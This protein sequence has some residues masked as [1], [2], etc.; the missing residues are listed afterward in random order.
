MRKKLFLIIL[1]AILYWIIKNYVPY[2]GYILYPITLLVTFFHETGHAFFALITG[3]MVEGI[4]I[5]SDGSGFARIGGGWSFLVLPGGYIGSALWGNLLLYMALYKE[6]Y[7]RFLLYFIIAILVFSAIV[8][9]NSIGTSALLIAFAAFLV[10]MS[11]QKKG[12]ISNVLLILG[13]TSLIYIIMDFNGGPSSDLARFTALIPILPAFLWAIVWLVSVLAL[14][15]AILI[16][17]KRI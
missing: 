12:I 17:K 2:S 8:W 16:R 10:W 5:N 15:Y 6:K 13:T 1:T 14:T 3:G 9:F 7:S 4:Q 11:R